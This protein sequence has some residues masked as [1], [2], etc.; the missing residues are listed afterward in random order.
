M[1]FVQGVRSD[2][3]VRTAHCKLVLFRLTK[4]LAIHSKVGMLHPGPGTS[5]VN[6]THNLHEQATPMPAPFSAVNQHLSE[7]LPM[8][9]W[10]FM[11]SC[12]RKKMAEHA[13][14]LDT[15]NKSAN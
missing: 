1:K 5:L 7:P 13:L 10:F 2:R 14:Q 12:G 15:L 9:T 11:T 6:N 3:V 4:S 8:G